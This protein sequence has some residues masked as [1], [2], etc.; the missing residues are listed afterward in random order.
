MSEVAAP[1]AVAERSWY[2]IAPTGE[3]GEAEVRIYEDIGFFG[4]S[5]KRFA[6]DIEK[7]DAKTI[8]VRLNTYGGEAFDGIAIHNALKAHPANIVVHID[9]I[10]ASAGSVVAMAG[11][12]IRMADNAFLMIHEAR[13][14][15]MG[16]ADDMRHYADLLD[17]INDNIASTYQARAGKTRRHWRSKMADETWYGASEAK[18]EGLIDTIDAPTESAK[19]RF[20]FRIY[21]HA[22]EKA[23]QAWARNDIT[24][25]E[26]SLRSEPEP[27][28]HDKE[29]LPMADTSTLVPPAQPPVAGAQVSTG[30]LPSLSQAAVQSYIEKGRALGFSAGVRAAEDRCRAIAAACPGEPSIALDAFLA[31][32]DAKTAQLVYQAGQKAKQDARAELLKKEEEI[33]RLHA[34]AATGG[35][36]GVAIAPTNDDGPVLPTGLDPRSQAEMEYDTNPQIRSKNPNKDIWVRFR[37]MQLRGAVNICTPRK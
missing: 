3:E 7:L 27:V 21:N 16:E 4:V 30:D 15:V 19:A 12:E 34:V 29:I 18:D 14:G 8:H 33:A 22:P 31:G 24:A 13:G 20:D 23:R 36:G 17:K 5:A 11:D 2:V 6:D 10:A 9:G 28:A 25:P 37:E 26:S 32:Q 35:H 1:A